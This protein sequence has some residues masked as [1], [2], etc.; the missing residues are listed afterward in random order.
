MQLLQADQAVEPLDFAEILDLEAA[1]MEGPIDE[2]V[3]FTVDNDM[4]LDRGGFFSHGGSPF[5]L[6]YVM[7]DAARAN[8]PSGV[9]W[10]REMAA[11]AANL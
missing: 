9:P 5:I 2:F 10:T 4:L 6:F 7:V 11:G 3:P 1:Q 8:K